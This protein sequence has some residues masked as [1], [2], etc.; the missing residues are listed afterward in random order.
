M[1]LKIR[2]P[3]DNESDECARLIYISGPN[4]YSYS[5]VAGEPKIY[6]FLKLFYYYPGSMYS[7]ENAVVEEENGKIRGLLLAYPASDMM[8]MA[9][10]MLKSIKRMIKIGGLSNFLRMLFRLRLNKYL[11]G[12]ENDEFYISNLAVFEEYR[13]QGIATKL[14]DRA[15][16][17]AAA[18]GL[19]KL[20]LYVEIDNHHAKKVYEKRGFQEVK[21]V[22]LPDRYNKYN[23]YGSYK[24]IKELGEN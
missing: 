24:M 21:K 5:F 7:K 6:E 8:K 20:S 22:I 16:E 17:M 1:M 18:K 2:E 13:G 11:P 12:V 23:L 14:L 3:Y 19:R 4:I 9:F 15:E 10:R